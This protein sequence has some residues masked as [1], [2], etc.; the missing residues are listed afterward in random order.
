MRAASSDMVLCEAVRAVGNVLGSACECLVIEAGIWDGPIQ[1]LP[2]QHTVKGETNATKRTDRYALRALFE[3]HTYGA[4][5]ARTYAYTRTPTHVR[6]LTYAYTR[7]PTR[8]W[9]RMMMY[10][11][12]RRRTTH[13]PMHVCRKHTLFAY[14][15]QRAYVY[16]RTYYRYVRIY[17]TYVR[18]YAAVS[19][20]SASL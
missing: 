13:T 12:L 16:I 1:V 9:Y 18:I 6:L 17:K 4:A 7:T 2:S 14:C 11:R 10:V 5:Y 19:S 8:V 3:R 20:A 15:R